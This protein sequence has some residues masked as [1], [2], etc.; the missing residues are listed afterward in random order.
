MRDFTTLE[1][2]HTQYITIP[3]RENW[4]I[5]ID[6]GVLIERNV[7]SKATIT[8]TGLFKFHSISHGSARFDSILEA[9]Q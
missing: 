4:V 8:F 9:K 2:S 7:F 6:E 3:I 1:S 5:S